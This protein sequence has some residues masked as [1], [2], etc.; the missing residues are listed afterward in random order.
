MNLSAL[1]AK[2]EKI[3]SFVPECRITRIEHVIMKPGPNG[4]VPTGE[5]FVTY[6]KSKAIKT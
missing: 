1:K 2:V 5:I 4:A 3:K 6:P